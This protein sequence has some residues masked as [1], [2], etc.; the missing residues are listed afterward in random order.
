MNTYY[1]VLTVLH[2]DISG[3]GAKL[4]KLTFISLDYIHVIEPLTFHSGVS[5]SQKVF[6]MILYAESSKTMVPVSRLGL[7]EI[8]ISTLKL[9]LWSYRLSP[10]TKGDN[11]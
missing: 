2:T 1:Y 11:H 6:G 9:R 4:E 5:A 7:Q 10:N 8:Q 3:C